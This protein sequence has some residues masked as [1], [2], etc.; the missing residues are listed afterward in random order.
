[1]S[2]A[3]REE[4]TMVNDQ[5]EDDDGRSRRVSRLVSVSDSLNKKAVRTLKACELYNI[6]ILVCSYVYLVYLC[7]EFL[8]LPLPAT[9]YL[10]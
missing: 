10:L 3:N 4:S 9:V 7:F 1:M 6:F 2:N 8:Y 5:Q